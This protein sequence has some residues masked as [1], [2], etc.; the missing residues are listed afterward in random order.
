MGL[1]GRGDRQQECWRV[2][3]Q[4]G[5]DDLFGHGWRHVTYSFSLSPHSLTGWLAGDPLQ[6]VD[7]E[8]TNRHLVTGLGVVPL[9]ERM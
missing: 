2:V 5:Q 3:V 4:G 8:L 1:G 6:S 9:V 7:V